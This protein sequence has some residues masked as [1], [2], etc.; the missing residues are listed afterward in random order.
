MT[1]GNV[2]GQFAYFIGMV[3]FFTILGVGLF[4]LLCV[5]TSFHKEVRGI[6]DRQIKLLS[7]AKGFIIA[8][9]FWFIGVSWLYQTS[10][11]TKFFELKREK[12][13]TN[14]VW[15]VTY[16]YP[17]RSKTIPETDIQKF[18]GALDWSRRTAQHALV[19]E[20]KDGNSLMSAGLPPP[21]FK[22]R[23]EKLERFGIIIPFGE[24]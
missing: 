7:K 21:V 4:V 22:E 14:V 11:G 15:T 12:T 5:E 18:T 19:I 3:G 17:T 20:L 10:L 24:E 2:R 16:H 1:F 23:S 6:F 8:A 13:G 9:S